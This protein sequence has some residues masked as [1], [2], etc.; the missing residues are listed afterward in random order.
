[1]LE[2]WRHFETRRV[3]REPP[4]EKARRWSPLRAHANAVARVAAASPRDSRHTGRRS[5]PVRQ[6]APR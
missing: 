6:C 3:R 2:R 5:A 4:A 1:V